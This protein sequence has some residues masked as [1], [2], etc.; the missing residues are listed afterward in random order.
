MGTQPYIGA[1][2]ALQK[3]RQYCAYQERCH[4]EVKEKLYEFG[5]KSEQAD[6]VISGLI[7]DK[8]LDEERY[9]I[10][11]A[12]GKF[13]MKQW[14]KIKIRYELKSNQVSDYCIKK[15]L[16]AIDEAD[17]HQTLSK[18]FETKVNSLKSEKNIQSKKRKVQAY[19]LQ[20]GFE[21][22]L[23]GELLRKL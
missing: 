20:K 15:A 1:E 19:L 4:K 10:A 17:Y 6:E 14:G 3:I 23:I 9:A 2:K 7:E 13:R 16:S 21:S 11:F 8:F 5:L 22:S 12:G 18:L